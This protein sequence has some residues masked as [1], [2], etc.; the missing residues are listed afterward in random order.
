MY[1]LVA[2]ELTSLGKKRLP[3]SCGGA[4]HQRHRVRGLTLHLLTADGSPEHD[5]GSPPTT[6][7]ATFLLTYRAPK[8]TKPQPRRI[9]RV[10]AD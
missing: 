4:L 1:F 3:N 10:T 5:R 9:S 7:V 2:I 8:P 6:A